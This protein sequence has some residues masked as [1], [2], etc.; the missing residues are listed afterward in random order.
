MHTLIRHW[1][2]T[3]QQNN[4]LS[5]PI[6]ENILQLQLFCTVDE[7]KYLLFKVAKQEEILR[8]ERDKVDKEREEFHVQ[9]QKFEEEM[10]RMAEMHQIQVFKPCSHVPTQTPG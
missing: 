4:I 1:K 7:H 5:Q 3:Q 9:K 10:A 8:Q 6:F 2:F